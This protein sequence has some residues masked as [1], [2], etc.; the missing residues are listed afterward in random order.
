[1]PR[2]PGYTS[3]QSQLL[4]VTIC[5]MIIPTI[6]ISLRLATRLLVKIRLWWDDYFAFAA[7][8]RLGE[9]G[10]FE[11]DKLTWSLVVLLWRKH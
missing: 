1:M 11:V 9:T 7:L 8:V 10:R 6:V 2:E 3:R 4:G 5:C